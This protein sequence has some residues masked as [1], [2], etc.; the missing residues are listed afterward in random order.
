V[1][2][3]YHRKMLADA[4]RLAAF[5]TA[6]RKLIVPGETVVADIGAGTG[7]LAFL[8]RK[9]GA[10]E[11]HL[12]EHGDVIRLAAELAEANG[13]DGL[14]FHH[15][16]S[17][18]VDE[19]PVLADI[20]VSETLGNFALEEH[21]IHTLADARARFLKP[22][23]TVLPQA[24]RQFVAPVVTDRFHAELASWDALGP[25]LDFSAAKR[26]SM[27]N[28]YVH[29]IES[30][31]LAAR[32][33]SRQWDT[34]DLTADER[35]ARESRVTWQ[36]SSRARCYG[37]AMWWECDLLAGITLS[38]SPWEPRTHWDQLYLPLLNPLELQPGDELALSI[39]CDTEP[40]AGTDFRWSV[41]QRRA[42]REIAA[43]DRD[44]AEGF[45]G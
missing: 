36:W 17:T 26:T 31:D 44:I 18:E 37:F 40:E 11:V 4:P 38:T 1:L 3:D 22:G 24:I 29:A 9:L 42:G 19:P 7:I 10:R 21:I 27:D 2:I 5:E 15:A 23:G 32:E 13:I 45:L 43:E 41:V 16:Y 12:Y 33:D 25:G 35:S 20:V 14:V 28:L 34:V 30:R 8:A 6:L 39:A